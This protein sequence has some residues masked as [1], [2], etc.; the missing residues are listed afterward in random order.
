MPAFLEG[1]KQIIRPVRPP[2]VRNG[3]E[4]AEATIQ[5]WVAPPLYDSWVVRTP[6]KTEYGPVHQKILN[7]WVAEGRIECGMKL[8]RADWSKWKRVERILPEVTP[9]ESTP[10]MIEEFPELDLD[11]GA[12]PNLEDA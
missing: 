1:P 8:L 12:M 9:T 5:K 11:L 4:L 6:D 7:T 10:G 3:V 2:A